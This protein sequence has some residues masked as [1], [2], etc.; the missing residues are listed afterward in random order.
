MLLEFVFFVLVGAFRAALSRPLGPWRAK[1]V[2]NVLW[3]AVWPT[4]PS[5]W[6]SK[7]GGSIEPPIVGRFC[8]AVGRVVRHHRKA[9]FPP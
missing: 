5:S 7:K 6:G 3:R 8:P 9:Q 1:L 4:V 2:G